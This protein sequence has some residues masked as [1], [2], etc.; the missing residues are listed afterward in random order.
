M[1]YSDLCDYNANYYSNPYSVPSNGY[2]AHGTTFPSYPTS[3]RAASLEMHMMTGQ[4]DVTQKASPLHTIHQSSTM[5]PAKSST[6]S[7]LSPHA[8]QLDNMC[9]ELSTDESQAGEF[10]GSTGLES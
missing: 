4:E 10:R 3:H 8:Q 5:S 7:L 2:Y 1:P 6:S 9:Q